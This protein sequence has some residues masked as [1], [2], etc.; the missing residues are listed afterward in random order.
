MLDIIGITYFS[1]ACIYLLGSFPLNIYEFIDLKNGIAVSDYGYL[2]ETGDFFN[3]SAMILGLFCAFDSLTF[4]KYKRGNKYLR[5]IQTISSFAML[6]LGFFHITENTNPVVRSI[7]WIFAILFLLV[8]PLSRIFILRRWNKKVS[9]I[10]LIIFLSLNI[11]AILVTIG[12]RFDHM[13]Y[14]EY[15]MW[16]AMMLVIIVSKLTMLKKKER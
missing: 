2:F 1:F 3:I 9:N 13:Y 8:Y 6:G 7:H 11:L 16:V 12:I 14:P 15:L 10:L 4:L 5:L